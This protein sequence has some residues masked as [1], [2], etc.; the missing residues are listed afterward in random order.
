MSQANQ[1]PPVCHLCV[2]VAGIASF[3]FIVLPTI[4]IAQ[5]SVVFRQIDGCPMNRSVSSSSD[6]KQHGCETDHRTGRR[7]GCPN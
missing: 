6:R 1:R 4:G 7:D 5:S 2:L 3:F